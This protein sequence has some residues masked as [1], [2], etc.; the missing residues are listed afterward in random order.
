MAFSA[1][2]EILNLVRG[3]RS[4]RKAAA[5]AARMPVQR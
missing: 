4:A 3:R 5:K 2:V 1:L